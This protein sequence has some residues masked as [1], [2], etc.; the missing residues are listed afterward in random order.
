MPVDLFQSRR[1]Y[2]EQCLFWYRDE[3]KQFTPDELVHTRVADGS[4]FAREL[5]G[6]EKR[7][8]IIGGVFMFDSASVT[9]MSPDDLEQLKSEDIVMYEGEIWIIRNIQKRKSRINQ[10]EFARDKNCSHYWYI[11]LR[12]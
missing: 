3:S 10:S 5:S 12:K 2:N 9:I 4:F 6:E 11:D 1:I 8:N 7:N